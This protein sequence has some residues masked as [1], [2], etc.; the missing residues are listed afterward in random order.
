MSHRIPLLAAALLSLALIN[1]AYAAPRGTESELNDEVKKKQARLVKLFDAADANKD[2]KLS[3]EEILARHPKFPPA[4]FAAMDKNSDGVVERSEM[5]PDNGPSLKERFAHLDL[6]SD[7]KLDVE[8]LRGIFPNGTAKRFARMDKDS[9]GF[10]SLEEVRAYKPEG[11][12][13]DSPK[14]PGSDRDIYVAKLLKN[15]DGDSNAQLTL[16]EIQVGKPGFPESAFSALDR[17]NN[18]I[19][20][21]ADLGAPPKSDEAAAGKKP[22]AK[23]QA[24]ADSPAKKKTAKTNGMAPKADTNQDGK[25]SFEEA[26]AVNPSLTRERFDQRDKN[27]NGFLDKEDRKKS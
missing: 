2:D 20:D 10:L 13:D 11:P 8:E 14:K 4:R 5:G 12:S 25:V 9:D 15:H 1:S 18:G 27:G 19:L 21:T 23:K 26:S 7:G 16:A 17:D 6:N 24:A 22:K 3:L